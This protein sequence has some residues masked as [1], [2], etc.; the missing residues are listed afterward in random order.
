MQL[1]LNNQ[2]STAVKNISSFTEVESNRKKF[3]GQDHPDIDIL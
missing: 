1:K 3:L 2:N